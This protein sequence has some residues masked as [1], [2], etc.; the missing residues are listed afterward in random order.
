MER[1]IVE[2]LNG[3]YGGI[4]AASYFA[5]DLL[6]WAVFQ[7]MQYQSEIVSRKLTIV[8]ADCYQIEVNFRILFLAL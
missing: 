7:R 8:N 2:Y 6:I 3:G 5:F 4:D 1:I